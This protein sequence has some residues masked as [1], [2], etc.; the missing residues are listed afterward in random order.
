[1]EILIAGVSTGGP[2]VIPHVP[3][4]ILHLKLCVSSTAGV[5]VVMVVGAA[6]VDA[7]IVT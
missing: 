7:P 4:P 3:S 6:I 2:R 1:M 5:V